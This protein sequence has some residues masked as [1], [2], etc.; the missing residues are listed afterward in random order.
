[1]CNPRRLEVNLTRQIEEEC[2]AT[3]EEDATAHVDVHE[4]LER[5][6]AL[7]D[8]LGPSA[9]LGLAAALAEGFRGWSRVDGEEGHFTNQPLL[10]SIDHQQGA[11]TCGE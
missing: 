4:R 9:R 1:M 10:G 5:R 7:A 3:V 2:Q 8:R 6:I 11:F